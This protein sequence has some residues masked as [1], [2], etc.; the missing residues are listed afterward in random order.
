MNLFTVDCTHKASFFSFLFLTLFYA[1]T[2]PFAY[3]LGY[4]TSILFFLFFLSYLVRRWRLRGQLVRSD[5]PQVSPPPPPP[6]STTTSS[7]PSTL[8]HHVPPPAHSGDD[9]FLPPSPPLDNRTGGGG[10]GGSPVENGGT[11]PPS[12]SSLLPEPSRPSKPSKL[13]LG[14]KPVPP[15]KP[16][17]L[18]GLVTEPESLTFIEKKHHFES[19]QQQQ[20]Q[21]SLHSTQ[22]P[23]AKR[24]SFLSENELQKLREEQDSKHDGRWSR[25][26]ESCEEEEGDEEEEDV[27]DV[28]MPPAAAAQHM[29]ET[30]VDSPMSVEAEPVRQVPIPAVRTLKAERRLQERQ[31]QQPG[32]EEDEGT[33]L[34]GL[35][36]AEQRALEAEKRAAWRQARMKSLEE[37]AVQAQAMLARMTEGVE[38]RPVSPI[39]KAVDINI[40]EAAEQQTPREQMRRDAYDDGEHSCDFG[41]ALLLP[42]H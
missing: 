30:E 15:P 11:L 9:I 42:H 23:E 18:Q 31:L 1:T 33:R 7:A 24:F 32:Q 13:S 37:D 29:A 26:E 25:Q 3:G 41:S 36:D 38:A 22:A 2:L 40:D 28:D 8:Q 34:L 20:Q 19:M 6:P 5:R 4:P 10:G 39:F 35:T 16:R 12:V 14:P 27:D 17:K 21:G